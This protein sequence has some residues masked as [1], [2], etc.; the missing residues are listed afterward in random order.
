MTTMR[1]SDSRLTRPHYSERRGRSVVRNG[2]EIEK[3]ASLTNSLSSFFSLSETKT[4]REKVK[5]SPAHPGKTTQR[6]EDP[7]CTSCSLFPT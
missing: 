4:A 1:V 5:R 2:E 6:S 7:P 3:R